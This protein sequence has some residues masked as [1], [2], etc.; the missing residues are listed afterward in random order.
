MNLI[1][2]V[3]SNWGI[4]K[5]N[6]LLYRIKEDMQRFK[7]LTVGKIVVMGKNTY[8]SLPD[9]NRPLP[10]RINIVLTH[11]LEWSS[12]GVIVVHDID[13]LMI[14]LSQ[15]ETDDVFV[16]GGESIYK[17][18]L[19]YCDTSYVTKVENQFD[20][21][22]FMVNLDKSKDWI[23]VNIQYEKECNFWEYMKFTI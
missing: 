5:D 8:L 17:Q 21:D 9:K 18:L 15:Y 12:P 22:R 16:I 7:Q 1:V 20:A 11:D 2:T 6:K 13:S 14:E 19:P 3:D 10:D 23:P 4:G